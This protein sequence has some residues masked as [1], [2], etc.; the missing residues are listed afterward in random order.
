MKPQRFHLLAV[1]RRETSLHAAG[2][3]ASVGFLLPPAM[4]PRVPV[5]FVPRHPFL[6]ACQKSGKSD[7]VVRTNRE[8]GYPLGPVRL[9]PYASSD[10]VSRHTAAAFLRARA[11]TPSDY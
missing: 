8:F 4:L 10:A 5:S 2:E 6:R 1:F 3:I 9:A 7:C 11:W